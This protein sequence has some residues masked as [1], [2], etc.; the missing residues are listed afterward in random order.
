MVAAWLGSA[1]SAHVS[2]GHQC[3][4]GDCHALLR[5]AD[6]DPLLCGHTCCTQAPSEEEVGASSE[7]AALE[8]L[9]EQVR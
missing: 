4:N 6:M 7:E 5:L 9:Y 2:D 1:A 3:R 8:A